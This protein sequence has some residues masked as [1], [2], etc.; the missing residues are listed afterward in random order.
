MDLFTTI[1]PDI[2][3]LKILFGF[4][5]PRNWNN[6]I[7]I[8]WATAN[9]HLNVVEYLLQEPDLIDPSVCSDY[10]IR[11]ACEKG[12]TR[13]VTALLKDPRV[14]P[15]THINF[16]L[17]IASKNKH[18]EIVRLLVIDKRVNSSVLAKL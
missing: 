8:R 10:C 12:Y 16:P 2:S 18:K 3:K 11:T 1:G 5:I 6:N 15:G 17:R 13:I 14:N 9:G 4:L 7:C